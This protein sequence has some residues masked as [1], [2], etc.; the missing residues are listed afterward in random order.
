MRQFIP[1][2][3]AALLLF[4]ALTGGCT[5]FGSDQLPPVQ[6]IPLSPVQEFIVANAPGSAGSSGVISDP[7]FGTDIRITVEQ[8]FIS[9]TGETCRR[10]ALFSQKG[11]TEMVVMCRNASGAWKMAPRVWGQG[12][13]PAP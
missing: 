3:V 12:L 9:A 10:A 4:S 5:L 7:E 11:D 2:A 8:E 13:S 1:W 6:D